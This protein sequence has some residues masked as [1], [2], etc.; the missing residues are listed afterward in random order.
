MSDE[1]QYK[2]VDGEL[3]QLTPEEIAA[4]A[5]DSAQTTR[6]QTVA[7]TTLDM[8]RTMFEILTE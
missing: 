1:P 2:L 3:V 7:S 8:G 6:T 4:I 5:A